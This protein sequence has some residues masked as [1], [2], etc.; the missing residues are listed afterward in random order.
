MSDNLP[1]KT[2]EDFVAEFALLLQYK[3]EMFLAP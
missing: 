3:I 1:V 2:G